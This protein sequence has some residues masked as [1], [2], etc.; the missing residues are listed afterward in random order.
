MPIPHTIHSVNMYEPLGPVLV[1]I[2][3][4]RAELKE[5]ENNYPLVQK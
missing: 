2:F 4:T 3:Q 1:T 5:L